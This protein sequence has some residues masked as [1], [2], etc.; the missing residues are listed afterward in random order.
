MGTISEE[1]IK[2]AIDNIYEAIKSISYIVIDNNNEHDF[3]TEEYKNIL[4]EELVKLIKINSVL[5]KGV[6]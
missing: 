2:N 3:Y 5:K 1:K 6:R 4:S